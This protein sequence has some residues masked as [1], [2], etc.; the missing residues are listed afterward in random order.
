MRKKSFHEEVSPCQT[1]NKCGE[2]SRL[3]AMKTLQAELVFQARNPMAASAARLVDAHLSW[4]RT[5]PTR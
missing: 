1:M 2:T 4:R 5:P 3:S